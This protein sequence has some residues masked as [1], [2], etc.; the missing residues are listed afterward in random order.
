MVLAFVEH[1]RGIL[2]PVSLQMLTYA[3]DGS[4]KLNTSLRAVLIGSDA[5][6]FKDGLNRFGVSRIHLVRHPLLDNYAPVAWS[7]CIAQLIEAIRPSVVMAAST[8][9]GNEVLAWMGAM[10][11]LPTAANC[12]QLKLDSLEVLRYRC[13]GSLLEECRL[14]GEPKLVTIAPYVEMSEPDQRPETSVEIV[15]PRLDEKD[16]RVRVSGR[17]IRTL[18]VSTCK[19][20]P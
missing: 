10:A 7:K 11:G 4:E 16:V 15:S 20:P 17:K 8:D 14:H 6:D 3:R 9:R 18:R 12:V 1:E 2:N 5:T 19:R 13:G